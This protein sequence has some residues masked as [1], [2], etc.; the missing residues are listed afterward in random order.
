MSRYTWILAALLMGVGLSGCSSISAPNWCHPGTAAQ[1]RARAERFNPYPETEIGPN[2]TGA[3]PR[4]FEQQIAEPA[5]A[6]WTSWP[7]HP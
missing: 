4:E 5:R 2:I 1:Q 6:R 7:N 3:R